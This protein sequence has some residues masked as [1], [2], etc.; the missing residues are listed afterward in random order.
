MIKNHKV[1]F[2]GIGETK[3]Y[4][5]LDSVELAMVNKALYTKQAI[6][7]GEQIIVGIDGISKE[8]LI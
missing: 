6:V 5:E 3:R 4:H 7:T 8:N 2:Q 1:I